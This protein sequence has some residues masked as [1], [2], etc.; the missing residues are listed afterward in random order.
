MHTIIC[1]SVVQYSN[2]R[3]GTILLVSLSCPIQKRKAI[4]T[5]WATH[6]HT[7]TNQCT[8]LRVRQISTTPSLF[9]YFSLCANSPLPLILQSYF[10][11]H[12][13]QNMEFFTGSIHHNS[14]SERIIDSVR[15]VPTTK[16][17]LQ[18]MRTMRVH[19]LCAYIKPVQLLICDTY[20]SQNIQT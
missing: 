18:S 8:L 10:T 14:P 19:F 9:A 15:L 5:T 11:L 12:S 2:N 17:N 1:T 6:T 20:G 13:I 7:Y 3:A 16:F 4:A